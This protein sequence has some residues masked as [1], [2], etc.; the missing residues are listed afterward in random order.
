M[1]ISS[2]AIVV[3]DY[4]AGI[5]FYVDRVGFTLIEDTDQGAGKRW[6]LVAPSP[7]AETRILLAR[8]QGETQTAAIGNQTGGRV[9]FFLHSDDFDA[10]FAR[11]RDNGVVFEEEPRSEAYGKVAVWRDPWGNRWDLLQLT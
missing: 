3:P 7:K 9:G 5:A 4:D 10:D 6:V 1:H 8:A 2:F 11:L